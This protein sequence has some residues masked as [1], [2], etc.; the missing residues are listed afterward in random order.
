MY[1]GPDVSAGEFRTLCSEAAR[2]GLEAEVE[3]LAL[4]YDR[5]LEALQ[6]KLAR[7]ERELAGDQSEL[8][9]RK[10]EELGTAAE[11]V[12]SLF[13]GRKSSRRIS[14]SLS[15][16]RMTEQAKDD[17]EESVDS[18]ADFKKQI[19]MLEKEKAAALEAVNAR[20]TEAANDLREI[21]V[22]AKK[23][24]VAPG[25]V[26]CGMAALPSRLKRVRKCWSFPVSGSS[27]WCGVTSWMISAGRKWRYGYGNGE[28]SFNVKGR[29]VWTTT[30]DTAVVEA[31]RMMADKDVGALV[32]V[33]SGELVGIFSERDYARKVVLQGKTS[34]ETPV[35]DVMTANVYTVHPEHTI[36]A[37][38][39]IMTEKHIRHLPVLDKNQ[40]VG[41]ISIGDVVKSII[42][43]Q[44]FVI[45]QLESYIT[46]ER[47]A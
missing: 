13:G 38:M 11:N 21:S 9:Q 33:E 42:S 4:A 20:W 1:A 23:T 27:E 46:G 39:A 24:D 17:V 43:E 35:R 2:S 30:P 28:T 25:S 32:V 8:S 15:K 34:R 14:S 37:C 29:N 26:W 3:K 5:K 47:P 12:F 40:V 36:G 31:L 19:A 16:R 18:I 10:M 45:E 41:L 44:Q 6:D 7:E 22:A